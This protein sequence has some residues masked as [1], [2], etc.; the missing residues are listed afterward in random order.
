MAG[1]SLD[2][3]TSFEQLGDWAKHNYETQIHTQL[4]DVT[5]DISK[6]LSEKTK[7][8][9]KINEESAQKFIPLA[10]GGGIAIIGYLLIGPIQTVT[11]YAFKGLKQIVTGFGYFEKI[12]GIGG[13]FKGLGDAVESAGEYVAY[14]LPALAGLVGYKMMEVPPPRAPE[15]KLGGADLTGRVGR[16]AIS[17]D[18]PLPAALGSVSPPPASLLLKPAPPPP[19]PKPETVK[20]I[21]ENNL[22]S[23]T[24]SERL[25]ERGKIKDQKEFRVWSPEYLKKLDELDKAIHE[26][27]SN[28]NQ[29]YEDSRDFARRAA[30]VNIAERNKVVSALINVGFSTPEAEAFVPDPR[31]IKLTTHIYSAEGKDFPPALEEF[32]KRFETAYGEGGPKNQVVGGRGIFEFTPLAAEGDKTPRRMTWKE[33]CEMDDKTSAIT[34]KQEYM[35]KAIAFVEDRYK[36]YEKPFKSGD[37][38]A[39]CK[40]STH[41][42][43]SSYEGYEYED[44]TNDK[45]N[46]TWWFNT[47][48]DRLSGQAGYID[49]KP[50]DNMTCAQEHKKIIIPLCDIK[51]VREMGGFY[52]FDTKQTGPVY[53]QMME[54]W[55]AQKKAVDNDIKDH[56]AKKELVKNYTKAREV[57]EQRK[58]NILN[59]RSTVI[60]VYQGED[61]EYYSVQ[62]KDCRDQ[63]NPQNLTIC[64]KKNG[65]NY[66]FTDWKN[67][68]RENGAENGGTFYSNLKW[69]KPAIP[70]TLTAAEYNDLVNGKTSPDALIDAQKT[71]KK[72]GIAV[73][74]SGNEVTL[75]DTSITVKYYSSNEATISDT[76][77]P[78]NPVHYKVKGEYKDGQF[79]VSG[80]GLIGVGDGSVYAALPPDKKLVVTDMNDPKSWKAMAADVSKVDVTKLVSIVEQKANAN[81]KAP[82]NNQGYVTFYDLR[83]YKQGQPETAKLMTISY[84]KGA[85]ERCIFT[86]YKEGG[87]NSGAAWTIPAPDSMVVYGLDKNPDRIFNALRV[88]EGKAVEAG[89]EATKNQGG[90]E[91]IGYENTSEEE[92]NRI[93]KDHKIH[94]IEQIK[95]NGAKLG[96]SGDIILHGHS[97]KYESITNKGTMLTTFALDAYEL[98]SSSGQSYF[99]PIARIK[100]KH[101]NAGDILKDIQK[102]FET[103]GIEEDLKRESA[104]LTEAK[105]LEVKPVETKPD[106]SPA[107][108]LPQT[109]NKRPRRRDSSEEVLLAGAPAAASPSPLHILDMGAGASPVSPTIVAVASPETMGKS[110]PSPASTTV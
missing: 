47:A 14:A 92:R 97:Y 98:K 109:N 60:G 100:M 52:T 9:L 27:Q 25:T 69:Q 91:I 86:G 35:W 57:M 83:A 45:W 74:C 61:K 101:T 17:T 15:S 31:T 23:A 90:Y 54:A 79:T 18:S 93:L 19:P 13:M 2:K 72:S 43:F 7:D 3:R 26:Y 1:D 88:I 64:F 63:G 68:T 66:E 8:N 22:D 59:H 96:Y 58:N 56:D 75:S 32:I 21:K 77:D 89:Y 49:G 38:E 70:V 80:L 53:R 24:A 87:V 73:K 104:K 4:S 110:N 44:H 99:K 29:I 106:E 105:P 95:I 11:G 84:Y 85:S 81:W 51:T 107:A 50:V 67:G 42:E 16:K 103:K 102:A 55:E 41:R 33:M 37:K 28:E 5:V 108:P 62:V 76:S 39:G 36:W 6:Q 30:G 94:S 65:E 82:N 46:T 10:V 78:K 40:T 20:I 71:F 12:P 48:P 34:L